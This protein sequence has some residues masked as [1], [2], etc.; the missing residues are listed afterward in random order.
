[1]VEQSESK[2]LR[3]RQIP[4]PLF[5][6]AGIGAA[7]ALI[8]FLAP[9]FLDGPLRSTIEKKINRDL[10][11]Y[12]VTLPGLHIRL[13]DLSLTLKGLTVR[14]QAHPDPPLAYFPSIKAR[15]HWREIF[16]GKLFAEFVLKEPNLHINLKQ[17]QNEAAN[18]V[19]IRERG[20]QQAVEDIYPL[21]IN[22]LRVNEGSITYI[23]Q[24]PKR[25]L[26]LSHMNLQASNIRNIH[27]PD[28][29]YP[30][31]FHLDTSIFDT[32]HGT[33]DGKANFLAEPIPGVKAHLK[34]ENVPVDYFRPVIA[35]SN[36]SISG[37]VL[38]ASGNVE[39]APKV[40][41]AH[42]DILTIQGMKLDYIHSKK[43]AGAELKKA[44]VVGKAA[45]KLSNKPGVLISADQLNLTGCNL[46]IV[47]N[48][49]GKNYRIF[50]S[51]ANFRL[52]NFSNQFSQGSSKA[53]LQGKFMGSGSTT[54]S[55]E[56]RPEN[57]GPDLDL[58]IKVDTTS[59]VQMNDFLRAYGN[60][61]VSRGTFSLISEL[62]IKNEKISGYFKPF[63][64][65]MNVY[66][67]RQDKGK[68]ISGQ[69][70]ELMVGGVAQLLENRP[71]QQ[72]ATKADISGSLKNPETSTWQITV[73]LIKNAFFKAIRPS[74]EK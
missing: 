64:K 55:G 41:V 12:S 24:D 9:F 30:S 11:G 4:R 49:V 17:L 57:N 60:F 70:Y 40:K 66:D 32:G 31:S 52:S 65:D 47:N 69:A 37:G 8:L 36:L 63:F 34:L 56:F 23:D 20:W 2:L 44:V 33:I 67:R 3:K 59:L 62:N 13:I 73:E 71:R 26:V 61:D 39:Y 22:S 72:V 10:K 5:W 42:L 46:G 68:S 43:T 28:K 51:D 58:H 19:S 15:I 48:A 45:S 35:R 25:P 38:G 21:K 54:V 7:V 50:L 53:L 74:F 1:M 27:L 6:L 29:V 14:Q 18:K 16:S